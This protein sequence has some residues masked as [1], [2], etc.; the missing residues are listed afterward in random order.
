M[1]LD[2]SLSKLPSIGP[3]TAQKLEKLGLFTLRDLLF[4][5]PR[6]YLD[7]TSI[8]KIKDIASGKLPEEPIT[9]SGSVIGVANK[10]TRRRG[11][12]VTEGVVADETGSIK[13]VWFNQPYLEKMLKP[14]LNII[15]NG[16]VIYD[17]FANGFV[18]ESPIRANH[19]A[20]VPVY[21]QTAGIS[22]YLLA[23]MVQKAMVFLREVDEFLPQNILDEH[24]LFGIGEAIRNIHDPKNNHDLAQAQKRFAFDELFFI[25]LRANIAKAMIVRSQASQITTDIERLKEVIENLPYELTGDQKKAVWQISKDLALGTPMNRLLNGDVGSGKTVVAVLAAWIT[26]EAGFRTLVMAPTSILAVQHYETFKKLFDRKLS[27]GL[28]TSGRQETN[29]ELGIKNKGENPNSKSDI[30]SS[31]VIIGTQALI[32]KGVEIAN[33]GLVVTDE[34][35]R[36]GVKQRQSLQEIGRAAEYHPHFLS[37]TATPIP[38]TLHLALFGDLDLTLIKEKPAN[39]KEIKTR[40]V[41]PINRQKAYDF[42]RAQIKAGRQAFVICPLIE[43]SEARSQETEDRS[44]FEEDRKSVI[45]EYEKL[46][47]IF[48]EFTVAMLHG[49]MKAKEKDEVMERFSQNQSQ[50]LVSTSVIEVGVDIPNAS[51]AMIEDAERFGLSQLHQ[52]RGRVGRGE[53]QSFCFLFS[54]S[55]SEKSI[56]RLRAMEST[57]DGFR[58]AEIDLETRGPG[59]IF[60][61]E[62]SGMLDLKMASISDRELIEEASEAAKSIVTSIDNCPKLLNKLNQFEQNQHLE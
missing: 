62:Q 37:M 12:T 41:E 55:Q 47:K 44:L 51:V 40:Y 28:W 38:R 4:Y 33:V 46:K 32:Q 24:S 45:Q 1:N 49:K 30:L 48:P 34:Q 13:V 59:A 61:T 14:N 19:P 23:K 18:M 57:N 26:K 56:G 50:I 8:T 7:F 25:S 11:F 17:R 20:I 5:Y 43:E 27:I 29:K 53:H 39:R 22:S 58:L 15:L 3:K 10:K 35:H 31:D 9:I 52:F 42:I 54:S 2:Y 6:R 21:N 60:G 16:K 36:F